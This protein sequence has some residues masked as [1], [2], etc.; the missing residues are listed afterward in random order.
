MAAKVP[1]GYGRNRPA[2][3]S[4]DQPL[5]TAQRNLV[6]HCFR[7]KRIRRCQMCRQSRLLRRGRC[8][9]SKG[10]ATTATQQVTTTSATL[11]SLSRK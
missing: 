10:R 7:P 1:E 9:R 4:E 2:L 5:H 8:D 11:A 3:Q 6:N